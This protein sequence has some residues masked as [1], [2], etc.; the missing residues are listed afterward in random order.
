MTV[1]QQVRRRQAAVVS[2]DTVGYSTLMETDAERTVERLRECHNRLVAPAMGAH[3]GRLL[4]RAGDSWLVE[5]ASADVA[6]QFALDV[7]RGLR[8]LNANHEPAHQIW[9]RSGINFGDVIEDGDTFHGT[10]INI[11]V[12]LQSI[13]KPGGISFSSLVFE[14]LSAEFDCRFREIGPRTVKNIP[15]PVM[16]YRVVLE[17]EEDESLAT[18]ETLVDVS[19][20]VPG[21]ENRPAIAVLPFRNI[22]GDP[23]QEYFSDGLTDDII[24]SLAHFRS[25]PLIS[26]NSTF[27][28]K[29]TEI[30]IRRVARQLGARYVVDGSVRRA[31]DR[32][33]IT[34]RVTHAE[35]G[36][37][38]W[39]ER[40]D[41]GVEDLFALQD[42]IALSIAAAIE[43]ELSR[44]EQFRSRLRAVESLDDW[45]LVRR[46]LWHL[47]RLT[48]EDS[49]IARD[50]FDRALVR[51]P[52]SIEALIH[53]AWWHFW[54][55][56]TRRGPM[57]GWVE[58]QRLAR[59]AMALDRGDA[60]PLMIA[61]TAELMQGDADLGRGML[62]GAIRLNPSLARAYSILG[63][64]FVLAGEPETALEPL[65]NALRLS[66]NDIWIFHTFG[67]I[68]VA[69]YMMGDFVEA[70]QAAGESLRL[71]PRYLYAMVV[72]VGS[73]ARLG[74]MNE[75]RVAL[76]QLLARRPEFVMKDVEWLPFIDRHWIGYLAEGLV[77]AGYEEAA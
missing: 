64:S 45:E 56:W 49:M 16:V 42:E 39:S 23:Q 1:I 6:V 54:D 51:N 50:L 34:A 24:N 60:R 65:R 22:G 26:R 61:G 9:L 28:L 36:N 73:L 57:E 2:I 48:R 15:G 59:R 55:V 67:E 11:A 75:A 66:P 69:R 71:R 20:E 43:P 8:P 38:V 17:G 29:S 72:R 13:A 40:Y 10:G 7:Q 27:Q 63:T 58:M 31:G 70:L 12:R 25:F 19:R 14:R 77:L 41:G 62:E 3:G 35:Q 18:P 44:Q 4:G 76:K 68:A 37:S 21:L 30:D 33:R 46:G 53:L 5:F 74:R 47:D 32:L 52:D